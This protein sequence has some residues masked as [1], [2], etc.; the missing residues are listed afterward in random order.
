MSSFIVFASVAVAHGIFVNLIKIDILFYEY[1]VQAHISKFWRNS[2]HKKKE[3]VTFIQLHTYK[4]GPVY[5]IKFIR[6]LIP[7]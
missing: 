2:I 7:L 5:M 1:P 6:Y 4:F 3:M